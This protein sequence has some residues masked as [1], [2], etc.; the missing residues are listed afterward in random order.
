MMK[1]KRVLSSFLS[2]ALLAGVLVF[3]AT[4]AGNSSFTDVHDEATAEA[5]EILCALGVVD[6]NGDGTYQPERTLTR[7][8][9]CKMAIEVVGRG[10]EVERQSGRV[11]FSDVKADH[12]A[13]GYINAA[14][15]KP[16][17][18][19]PALVSGVG[20]G[21]FQPQQPITCG[22]A[23]TI[24]LRALGYSDQ[25][26]GMGLRWYDG[27][28]SMA[29]TIGL[30]DGL[31]LRGDAAITRGQAAILFRNLLFTELKDSD[32]PYLT[33][34][35]AKEEDSAIILSV[36]AV[37]ADG[38][39]GAVK[40]QNGTY[41]TDRAAF[42]TAYEGLRG[43]V[44]LD[45]NG[46][47]LAI[48]PEETGSSRRVS[49]VSAQASYVKAA[50][51]EKLTV[52]K[53]DEISVYTADGAVLYSEAWIDLRPGAQLSFHYSAAGKLEYIYLHSSVETGAVVATG[54]GTKQFSSL[55]PSG[56]RY[57]IYKN[58]LPASASDI[59]QYDVAT[60]DR[61]AK[62]LQISDLKLTG[63]YE[64]VYPNAESPSL[65]TVMGHAFEV[66]PGAAEDLARMEL[67]KPVTL[68]LT[69]DGRVAGAVS[70]NKARSTVIGLVQKEST[71]DKLVVESINLRGCT[72]SGAS[73][74]SQEGVEQLKGQLVTVSSGASGRITVS[75]LTGSTSTNKWD[76]Q[77]G[78]IGNAV[79]ADN[80]KIFEKVGS[81][82]ILP[83]EAEDVTC[84]VVPASRLLY[85]GKDYAGRV[86]LLILDDVTGDGYTYG[87]LTGG[88]EQTD[89]FH[90]EPI[91]NATITVYSADGTQTL[92]GSTEIPKSNTPG[93]VVA[94]L[95]TLNGS[96]KAAGC[97]LLECIKDVSRSA[98]DVV[99]GKT[100]V[101]VQGTAWP[102]AENVVCYNKITGLWFDSLSEARAFSDELTLYYDKNPEDGGKIRLVVVE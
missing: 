79:V 23:V 42:S 96:P 81:S 46:K 98:F 35:G 9:F 22:A 95:N 1:L 66:L 73:Y 54:S 76:V 48:H 38:T 89:S 63:V 50:G 29:G 14:A 2:A 34:L 17:A 24:L 19:E 70:T 52:E 47:V 102:V 77:A 26:V 72:F 62:V 84:A 45:K 57:A 59:R 25:D 13:R 60:Y 44:V 85:V 21:L 12:W 3:P 87:F 10:G 49:I 69:L 74:R 30:T 40:T 80:V 86:D 20:N 11:I 91:Y 5:V 71:P 67:G 51:G 58:G 43:K 7:A 90:G 82:A 88:S 36:D 94:S 16:S 93:G 55:I 18:N 41:R 56:A 92:F 33:K 32:N 64:N 31:S 100:T 27:Y 53:P 15:T 99:D 83:V 68:L 101:T 61:A 78:T 39:V 65:V 75:P 8:E 97:V 4:A 28:I 37:A 6:G